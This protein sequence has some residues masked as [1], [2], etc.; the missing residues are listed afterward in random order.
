MILLVLH[1][2]NSCVWINIWDMHAGNM[3]CGEK[4]TANLEFSMDVIFMIFAVNLLSEK[5]S[6][7]IFY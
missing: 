4:H 5:F 7:S 1:F 6:S 2:H 3:I